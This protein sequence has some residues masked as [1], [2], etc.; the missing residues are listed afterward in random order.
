MH[1]RLCCQARRQANRFR[2]KWAHSVNMTSC[3]RLNM[4]NGLSLDTSW[5]TLRCVSSPCS[6][7]ECCGKAPSPA[8]LL[9]QTR[10]L[11]LPASRFVLHPVKRTLAL[12]S[13]CLRDFWIAESA[14]LCVLSSANL[15]SQ[16]PGMKTSLF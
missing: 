11:Y 15:G 13:Q 3:Y 16:Q 12:V 5:P 2:L 6:S 10:A 8:L 4:L 7:E 1:K 9:W 14:S